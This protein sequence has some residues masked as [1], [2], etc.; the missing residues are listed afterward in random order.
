MCSYYDTANRSLPN[1]VTTLVPRCTILA[2]V[3]EKL[4]HQFVDPARVW[5]GRK[6]DRTVEKIKMECLKCNYCF[7]LI[8][9]FVTFAG[10]S[11]KERGDLV[12]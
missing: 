7:K 3:W 12:L 11:G 5:K 10:A 1:S 9:K 8:A 4:E 6:A 2:A